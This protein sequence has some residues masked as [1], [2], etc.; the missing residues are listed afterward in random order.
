LKTPES[1]VEEIDLESGEEEEDFEKEQR[2]AG[3]CK[4]TSGHYEDCGEIS[5][6][7]RGRSGGRSSRGPFNHILTEFGGFSPK[8]VIWGRR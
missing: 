6:N 4:N 2:N 1:I 8:S 5:F 7:T 3:V